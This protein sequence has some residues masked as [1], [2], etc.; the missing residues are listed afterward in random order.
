MD[1]L[2]R[3]VENEEAQLHQELE[4]LEG[5]EVLVMQ[6]LDKVDVATASSAQ[7]VDD[8]VHYIANHGD[9]FYQLSH[10]YFIRL[11]DKGQ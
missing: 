11:S 1:A 5:E 10:L 3:E 2:K 8:M 4:K 9:L 7:K 6:G